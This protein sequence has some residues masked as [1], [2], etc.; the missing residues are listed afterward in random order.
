MIEENYKNLTD[1]QKDVYKVIDD[2]KHGDITQTVLLET[3][4]D[5]KWNLDKC[6]GYDLS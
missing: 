5:I 3:L 2:I 4:R 1:A 6:V